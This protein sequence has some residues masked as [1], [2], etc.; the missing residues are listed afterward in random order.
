MRP[1]ELRTGGVGGFTFLAG[2]K[3]ETD[4][5]ILADIPGFR[6][7]V[8]AD[9]WALRETVFGSAEIEHIAVAEEPPVAPAGDVKTDIS[10]IFVPYA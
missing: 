5:P 9:G 8:V 7:G 3:A 2:A 4:P 1:I 10:A 6:H